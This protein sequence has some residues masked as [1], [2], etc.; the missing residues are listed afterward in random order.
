[1]SR[2]SPSQLGKPA[3]DAVAGR[4]E[5]DRSQQTLSIRVGGPTARLIPVRSKRDQVKTWAKLDTLVKFAEDVGL[6]G[7]SV[8][9]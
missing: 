3:L 2:S 4:W 7:L 8:E 1:M 9:F 6:E 5:D